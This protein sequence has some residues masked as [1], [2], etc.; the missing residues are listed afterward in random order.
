MKKPAA[1]ERAWEQA[2]I[3]AA[4]LLGA[5][6]AAFP[7][8]LSA[9]PAPEHRFLI[10]ALLFAAK[11]IGALAL[12]ASRP[13]AGIFTAM[14]TGVAAV[15]AAGAATPMGYGLAVFALGYGWAILAVSRLARQMVLDMKAARRDVTERDG[16]IGRTAQFIEEVTHEIRTPLN[17]MLGF[18]EVLNSAAARDLTESDSRTYHALLLDS[19][20]RLSG[21]VAD[22]CDM[23]RLDRD[24]L[25]LAEH[26]VDAAEL[27][28]IAIKS[29]SAAA[30]DA[31]I[32]IL[33]TVF[34]GIELRCDALRISRA[35][36]T[37]VTRAVEAS[38]RGGVVR[39]CFA[40][41]ADG[42]LVIAITDAGPALAPSERDGIFE[43]AISERG[44]AG[45]A[46]PIARHYALLH[47][48]GLEFESAQGTGTT[49]RLILPA[50]RVGWAAGETS[51]AARAA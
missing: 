42:G 30:D 49:A 11:G 12:A 9:P 21:F 35:I 22:V 31:D 40:R 28:E 2:G 29:C 4:A 8:V 46:L 26:E 36:V 44:M 6:W 20:R 18:A 50:G 1:S 33:A 19:N 45:L 37:L 38:P 3:A 16:L 15:T 10:V 39:L 17:T 43:P 24:R 51:A 34:D 27:V 13:S 5:V 47:G 48:G 14:L 32:T 41:A 25:H 7:I 23:V